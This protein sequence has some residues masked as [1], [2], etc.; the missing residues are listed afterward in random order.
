[1]NQ[2]AVVG[3][4]ILD[5]VHAIAVQFVRKALVVLERAEVRIDFLEIR[6]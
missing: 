1:M 3:D 5:Q 2:F 6:R 4:D